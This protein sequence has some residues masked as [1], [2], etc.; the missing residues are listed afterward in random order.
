[1]QV[2]PFLKEIYTNAENTRQVTP[3]GVKASS[4][5]F[6]QLFNFNIASHFHS[7]NCTT[8]HNGYQR[9][10]AALQERWAICR[11]RLRFYRRFLSLEL[12]V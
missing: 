2:V 7:L 11:S 1:M 6:S 12:E 5:G 9:N 4:R 3:G 8:G 10:G